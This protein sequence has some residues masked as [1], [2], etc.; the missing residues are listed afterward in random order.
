MLIELFQFCHFQM[1]PEAAEWA[2]A[3]TRQLPVDHPLAPAVWG[4]AALGA[5]VEGRMDPTIE[6]GEQS[7]LLAA[8][9][10]APQPFWGLLALVDAYG[11]TGNLDRMAEVYELLVSGAR[12]N[13]DPFWRV[14]GLGYESM[15][16]MMLSRSDRARA[17]AE[18]ALALARRWGTPTACSGPCT[19]WA[20]RWRRATIAWPPPPST[21]RSP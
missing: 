15:A 13:P 2:A 19:A 4:A 6:F 10:G 7:L 11:F 5:W 8:K 9:A 1:V 20:A 17:R 21:R 3:I 14:M 12:R 18:Q 16:L